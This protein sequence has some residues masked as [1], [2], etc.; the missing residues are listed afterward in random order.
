MGIKCAPLLADLLLHSFETDFLLELSQKKERNLAQTFNL[1]FRY[2]DDV[3]LVHVLAIIPQKITIDLKSSS[4]T[5]SP[6][7]N[8]LLK[9]HFTSWKAW[10]LTR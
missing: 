3:L 6:M 1:S 8:P 7:A 10:L 2:I 4:E 5:L 9:T